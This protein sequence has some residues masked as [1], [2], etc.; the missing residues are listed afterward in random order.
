MLSEFPTSEKVEKPLNG[1][2]LVVAVALRD[3]TSVQQSY[4]TEWREQMVMHV[5]AYAELLLRWQ[6]LKQRAELLNAVKDQTKDWSE[7]RLGIS[8]PWD[9]R[10]AEAKSKAVRCTYCRL[11]I[12]GLSFTCVRCGH[13]MH[14]KCRNASQHLVCAAGCGCV[15]GDGGLGSVDDISRVVPQYF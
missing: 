7:Y 8:A 13:V 5:T 15:C 14:L 6:L 2:K 10:S 12:K 1:K 11:P 9:P 4:I 3:N